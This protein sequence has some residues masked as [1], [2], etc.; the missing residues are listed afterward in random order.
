MPTTHIVQ[1]G[2][3]LSSIAAA[4]GFADWHFLYEHPL[5]SEFKRLR[6]NPNVIF[7]GDVIAIPDREP[8]A[9]SVPAGTTSR[10]R[11]RV[12]STKLRLKLQD[13]TGAPLGGRAFSLSIAGETV[14]GT[15]T[16][17]GL[18]EQVIPANADEGTLTLQLNDSAPN[19]T[20]TWTLRIGH[21]DPIE[22]VSGVQARLNNLGYACG[23]VDGIAGEKTTSAM[24]AF[25]EAAGLPAT[26]QIDAAS[27]NALREKHDG[28]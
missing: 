27:R 15:T 2:E 17:D 12:S 20:F 13:Q 25:Q 26:G 10:F 24:K 18:V 7:P 5:N 21:L 9:R 6:P 3:C 19:E 8:A 1:Q 11:V 22:T 16:A 23:E 28:A 4:E 14:E